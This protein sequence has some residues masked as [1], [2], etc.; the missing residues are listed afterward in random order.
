MEGLEHYIRQDQLRTT[1]QS[2]NALKNSVL[3]LVK[4]I[5]ELDN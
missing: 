1:K 5:K 4:D 2:K 3:Q